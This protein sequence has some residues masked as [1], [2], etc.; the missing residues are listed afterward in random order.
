M[1]IGNLIKSSSIEIKE[2][3]VNFKVFGIPYFCHE[4]QLDEVIHFLMRLYERIKMIRK[5]KEAL[6][7][8]SSSHFTSG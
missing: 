2:N 5:E 4:E 6:Q 8:Q 1:E 3:G 7:R